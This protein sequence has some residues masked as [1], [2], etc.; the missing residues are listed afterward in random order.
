[1]RDSIANDVD[2]ERLMLAPLSSDHS[3]LAR[4]SCGDERPAASTDIAEGLRGDASTG[5]ATAS[6]FRGIGGGTTGDP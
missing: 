6:G 3:K 4:P 1:M 2:D 5:H